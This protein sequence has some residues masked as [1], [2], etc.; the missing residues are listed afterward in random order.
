MRLEYISSLIE[1]TLVTV[2]HL[3]GKI[4]EL[5]IDYRLEILQ[6][7]GIMFDS[8]KKLFGKQDQSFSFLKE[9]IHINRKGSCI[10]HIQIIANSIDIIVS[11]MVVEMNRY[12]QSCCIFVL[13]C[14]VRFLFPQTF[15]I[16]S[17]YL[18]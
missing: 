5:A 12:T 15:F 2:F 11:C 6:S 4:V 14:R 9:A 8:F 1:G 17:P 7:G 3:T 16:I 13:E 18:H 10:F